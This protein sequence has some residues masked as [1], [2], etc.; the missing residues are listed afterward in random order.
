MGKKTKKKENVQKDAYPP[1]RKPPKG[2]WHP[3][4]GPGPAKTRGAVPMAHD[5][6]TT[7][8]RAF[9]K[10]FFFVARELPPA[11]HTRTLG[12]AKKKRSKKVQKVGQ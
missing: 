4:S 6:K 12:C 9:S 3:T 8:P 10:V 5:T 7:G 11:A 2:G 1:A